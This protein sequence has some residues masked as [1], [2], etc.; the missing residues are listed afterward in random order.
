MRDFRMELQAIDPPLF[1]LRLHRR[2]RRITRMG[3]GSEPGRH[4][5]DPVSMG[6][7]HHRR[8]AC[9]DSLKEI[10]AV[11]DEEIGPAVFP[12]RRLHDL[13]AGQVRHQLHAVTD[14][15][16]RNALVEQFLRNGRRLLFVNAGGSSGK[17]DA[18]RTIGQNGREG[19]RA[20]QNLRID[21][22]LANTPGDQLRVLRSEVENENAIVPEF[23][24]F[25][26][27]M[28]DS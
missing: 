24:D 18:L 4:T 23:H 7:P 26:E 21:L 2:D 9:A 15:Q 8:A 16:D 11:I 28:A 14:A 19:R 17:H 22:R 13:T 10:A 1:I 3:N 5:F 25:K 27:P 20:G 6:H 12:M